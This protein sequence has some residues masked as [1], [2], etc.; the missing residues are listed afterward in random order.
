M[1][2]LWHLCPQGADVA[3]IRQL[4]TAGARSRPLCG[5]H[6]APGTVE[7]H[8]GRAAFQPDAHH[9][10]RE[11]RFRH[12]GALWCRRRGVLSRL[13]PCRSAPDVA[14]W[15]QHRTGHG[16]RAADAAKRP[17]VEGL[18]RALHWPTRGLQP[19]WGQGQSLASACFAWLVA[20]GFSRPG[21]PRCVLQRRFPPRASVFLVSDHGGHRR[22]RQHHAALLQR[23]GA[24]ALD[25]SVAP[26]DPTQ[27]SEARRA[28]FESQRPGVVPLR[29]RHP[30]SRHG[31]GKLHAPE[32]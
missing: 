25:E 31:G 23:R 30:R 19:R 6:R 15:R 11:G 13:D 22:L 7:R 27:T 26:G 8:G 12:G 1:P 18:H 4:P 28:P 5:C 24:L 14:P 29:P 2:A 20:V 3:G 16:F 21:D 10:G 17:R 9:H 32:L